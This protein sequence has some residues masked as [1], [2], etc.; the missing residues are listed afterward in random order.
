MAEQS[1]AGVVCLFADAAV[2]AELVDREDRDF[3]VN[4]LLSIMALDAPEEPAGDLNLLDAADVLYADALARGLTAPGSDARDRFIARLFGAVTPAPAVV[5]GKFASLAATD[6]VAA[7]DW[8]YRMCRD[9]DYIRTREIARNVLYESDTPAGR[10]E[11][12]I[13][14]S[15]P[16]KDPKDIAAALTQKSVSYPKCQLCAQNPGYAGR[17]GFPARQN[18]RIIPVT[19]GGDPWYFQYS[20]YLYY[21][22]HCIVFNRTHVPMRISRAS[23]G[24]MGD[25]VDAFPH[26]FIG[27][28]A[29]L[30]IVGGSILTHDHFQGGR[31]VFAMEC[32]QEWFAFDAGEGITARALTWPT[33]C[34]KLSGRDREQVLDAADRLLTAWRAYDDPE[35]GIL[36]HT[37]AAHNTIT[38]VL[39]RDNGTYHLYVMLRNNR[40][41]QE[42]PLGLFHPHQDKH[43]IKKENIGL[44][45]AMGLFILP[46]RLLTELDGV[47][48]FM[49]EG[50]PLPEGS[51][52][53]TW[54]QALREAHP[55][56][57]V[58][59]AHRIVR[60]AVGQ[61]C[62]QVLTDT[63]VYKQNDEGR[64]GL[65][66]FLEKAGFPQT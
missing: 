44:I 18:H 50:A 54:A 16:E 12:T 60:G 45:E 22:E 13:N 34:L 46:G 42:H 47:A 28:N 1:A 52:H 25:F 33:T 7:T 56:T 63:G 43:H 17:P 32:A 11:I 30:P 24:R 64:K 61:I 27:S 19:L 58:D 49:A 29:D 38:P 51:P 40:T 62:H 53:A 37:D 59:T 10:L 9:A 26:Y 2:A 57:A 4:N 21:D 66:R 65:A 35:H 6:A 5:R 55:G 23:L 39:R 3:A 20:P 14:L 41:T 36:A 48:R 15:K 31:H 8:F